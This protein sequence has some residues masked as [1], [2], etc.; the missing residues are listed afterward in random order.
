V[1]DACCV[2]LKPYAMTAIFV[3]QLASIG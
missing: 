2:A 3:T 1:F